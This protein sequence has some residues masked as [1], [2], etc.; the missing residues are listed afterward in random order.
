LKNDKNKKSKSYWRQDDRGGDHYPDYFK[1]RKEHFYGNLGKTGNCLV[2][3]FF[4]GIL[5]SLIMIVFG[6][7][8]FG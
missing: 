5:G 4:L 7:L 8:I 2:L 1:R 3:I 6:D